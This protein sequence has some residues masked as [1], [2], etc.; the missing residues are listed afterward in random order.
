[1]TAN[2]G[3]KVGIWT[4]WTGFDSEKS[5]LF[6]EKLNYLRSLSSF[7]LLRFLG[8]V[9][10][11]NQAISNGKPSILTHELCRDVIFQA[12]C[13]NLRMYKKN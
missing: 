11:T 13:T 9:S 3:V 2:G 4:R 6:K 8:P 5:F 10:V 12:K 1:M 7:D